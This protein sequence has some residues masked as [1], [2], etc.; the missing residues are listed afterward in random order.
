MAEDLTDSWKRTTAHLLRAFQAMG[1]ADVPEFRDYLDHNELQLAADV[2]AQRG[3]EREDLPAT[4]WYA[5]SLAYASMGLQRNETLC[6]FRRLE[7]EQGFVEARL[8]LLSTEAGGRLGPLFTNYRPSWNI[9]NRTE[10]GTAELNDA[11]ITVEDAESLLPGQ[12][13]L[14]RLH[15]LVPQSWQA[16][17]VNDQLVMHE[18]SRVLG[19]AVVVRVK[20]PALPNRST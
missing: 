2:L 8:T 1:A 4:F 3:D 12:T 18:G 9:G 14:V 15:P 7:V 17:R 13:G 20:P 16:V 5:L 19:H 11:R 6:G 10:R